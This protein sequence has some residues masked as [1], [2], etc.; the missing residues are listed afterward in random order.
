MA[1]QTGDI[2][3]VGTLDEICFYRM[4]GEHF[5]RRK[6]SLS[7]KRFWKAKVFEGS[8]KSCDR[9][10]KAS[11]MA[12]R[13]YHTLPRVQ[14]GRKVFRA[15]VGRVKLRLKEGWEEDKIQQWFL[16]TYC[17]CGNKP[18]ARPNSP[19]KPKLRKVRVPVRFSTPRLFALPAPL[20]SPKRRRPVFHYRE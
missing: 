3:I 1:R 6:S 13:L 8:R 2:K 5:A 16:E 7:G 12:S 15:L 10:A 11:P 17:S 9:M 19:Q 14:K 18:A 20:P 4:A